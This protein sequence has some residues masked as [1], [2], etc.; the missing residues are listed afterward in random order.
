LIEGRETLD[1]VNMIVFAGSFTSVDLI[2]SAKG[3]AGTIL[4]NEK[5]K[6]ALDRFYARPDTLSLGIGN[7]CLLMLELGLITPN[8]AQKP[9]IT[10]NE[11]QK[12]ECAFVNVTIPTSHSVMLSSLNGSRLGIW[13]SH[14]EGKFILPTPAEHYN[15]AMQYSYDA[16]PANPNGSPQGVAAICSTDGRHLAMMPHPE[17]CIYPCNWPYYPADRQQDQI[18]PWVEAFVNAARWM[19]ANRP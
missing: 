8:D 6:A 11:S 2:S 19:A 5:A 10:H 1:D 15:I 12:M 9:Q 17:R 7:G 3:W 16:Y 14:A 13:S 4:Q 18:T